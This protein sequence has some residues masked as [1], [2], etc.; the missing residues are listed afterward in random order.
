[1]V[2]RAQDEPAEDDTCDTEEPAAPASDSLADLVVAMAK[3]ADL[4]HDEHGEAFATIAVNGH[5]ETWRASSRQFALWLGSRLYRELR[6]AVPQQAMTTAI[7]TLTAAALFDGRCQTVFSRIARAEGSIW[8]DLG[9]ETWRAIEIPAHGWRVVDNKDTCFVRRVGMKPLPVPVA[10]FDSLDRLFELLHVADPGVRI[11]V[12]A[13]LVNAVVP[14]PSYPI[15]SIT[16][17]QGSG[18]STLSRALQRLVDPHKV[19]GRSP[20][21]TEEDIAVAAQQAHVLV[22]ENLSSISV[23]LSDALCRVSTGAGF[24]ARKLYT[25]DE[26]RQLAFCRPVIIN[27][28][29]DLTTRSDLADRVV[30]IHLE[31]I[32]RGRR[33]TEAALWRTFDTMQPQLFGALVNLVGRVVG[34]ADLEMPLERM[35]E[36]SQ[37]G[38]KVAVALGMSADAF[39]SAYR[40][41]RDGSSLVALESSAI[42]PVL[43]RLVRKQPVRC[44]I[45]AMLFELQSSAD[46]HELRHPD[47]PHTPRALGNELRRLAPNL[48][49]IGIALTFPPRRK[50][51]LWVEIE[52]EDRK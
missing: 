38:A 41:N 5:R 9:D 30:S 7:N 45:G 16:G 48:A 43:L 2:P 24:A 36:Y 17:E 11:L 25:N 44:P 1:M 10:G 3:D 39:I 42:G 31:R 35:A 29:G 46:K 40:E 27:G 4:F 6:V 19:E 20:P 18:K 32:P 23:T 14:S 50:D 22:Y 52:E 47:W 21:R 15:L 34:M 12:T 8:I 26:E 51:G 37:I 28:I 49:R 13:W 33:Q